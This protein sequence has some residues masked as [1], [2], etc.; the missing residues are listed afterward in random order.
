MFCKKVFWLSSRQ[1]FQSN[2]CV[3]FACIESPWRRWR[4]LFRVFLCPACGLALH[5]SSHSFR[6]RWIY[7]FW[8]DSTTSDW[9]CQRIGSSYDWLQVKSAHWINL[10]LISKRAMVSLSIF[11][12]NGIWGSIQW[13]I[14]GFA[15]F[16]WLEVCS[17]VLIHHYHLP[18]TAWSVSCT[19]QRTGGRHRTQPVFCMCVQASRA[20]W[21]SIR[22]VVCGTGLRG[23]IQVK[24]RSSTHL[25][26]RVRVSAR[27]WVSSCCS[28]L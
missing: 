22:L 1:P 19:A 9:W 13:R 7:L 8:S 12:I 25:A 27:N 4:V 28:S 2:N 24:V 3:L 10:S 17:Q 20:L 18:A 21:R 6:L 14:W 11:G 15:S 23:G 16:N 5:H 26:C